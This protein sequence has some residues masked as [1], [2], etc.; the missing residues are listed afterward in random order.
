MSNER[1]C[2]NKDPH[3]EW[4][5][6]WMKAKADY[7]AAT[8]PNGEDNEASEAALNRGHELE[9]LISRTP[10]TTLAGVVTKL[11]FVLT[12]ACGDFT[13]PLHE[14]AVSGALADLESA[15]ELVIEAH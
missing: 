14:E 2:A 4:L 10:A 11:N 13:H 9:K 6:E 7:T 5:A 12:D 1:A 8:Q 3:P 15:V